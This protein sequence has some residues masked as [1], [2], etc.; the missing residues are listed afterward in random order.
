MDVWLVENIEQRFAPKAQL[1]AKKMRDA[2]SAMRYS[3]DTLKSGNPYVFVSMFARN[4]DGTEL[5]AEQRKIEEEKER[6]IK[7]KEAQVTY[8]SWLPTLHYHIRVVSA[9]ANKIEEI[10]SGK[11]SPTTKIV[12]DEK[13]ETVGYK[14]D[15]QIHAGRKLVRN[16]SGVNS[17]VLCKLKGKKIGLV[18]ERERGF[19][20]LSLFKNGTTSLSAEEIRMKLKIPRTDGSNYMS[21]YLGAARKILRDV[22]SRYTLSEPRSGHPVQLIEKLD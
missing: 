20:V 8:N 7:M 3:W 1:A 12:F 10:R 18:Q 11:K 15:I 19:K 5:T 13:W 6:Q 16:A 4:P 14:T 21:K 22:E 17:P 9:Y 2:I